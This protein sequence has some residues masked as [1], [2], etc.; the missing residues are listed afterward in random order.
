MLR[1]GIIGYGVRIKVILD[2]LPF[3][4]ADAAPLTKNFQRFV[5]DHTSS[6]FL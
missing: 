6:V 4:F 2:L 5:H 3:V 1:L